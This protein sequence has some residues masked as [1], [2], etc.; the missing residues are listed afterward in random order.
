MVLKFA[1]RRDYPVDPG[2]FRVLPVKHEHCKLPRGLPEATY[3][4]SAS[5]VRFFEELTARLSS[6]PS[7][8]QATIA[9]AVP[10]GLSCLPR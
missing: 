10:E 4:D 3:P 8:E 9:S 7:I 5:Q 6:E 2:L 1:E